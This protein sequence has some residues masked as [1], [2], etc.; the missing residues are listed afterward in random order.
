MLS[1]VL[2]KVGD[3]AGT[4]G[5][6]RDHATL[7]FGPYALFVSERRLEK[8]GRPV[9]L[10]GRAM[11]ILAAL[12]ARAG[13][14]VS[15]AELSEAAWPGMVVEEGSLRFH[16]ATLRRALGEEGHSGP[17]LTTVA[18]R[19]YCFTGAISRRGSERVPAPPEE[20][21]KP[22]LRLRRMVG[23][24][25]V[26]AEAAAELDRH[27]FLTIVGPPGIG[28]T[29]L[30][31]WLGHELEPEFEDSVAF[32]DLG[33]VSG[34]HLVQNA[35][36]AAIG[37]SLPADQPFE[38]LVSLLRDK[39]L[40]LIFDGCEHV[41]D[42]LA[43]LAELLFRHLPELSILTTSRES[44]R[45]EGERVFRMFPLACPP[46]CELN[47]ETAM[48][49]PAV[50][51][52]VDRL[53]ADGSAYS[54]T[55]E[56]APMVAEICR[57]LDGI[58]LA[59]ELAASR[60]SA[61]GIRKTASLLDGYLSLLWRGRRTAP[62]RHQTLSAALDWSHDLLTAQER[63]VFRRV[64]IFVGLF[65]IDAAVAVAGSP[66]MDEAAVLHVLG[67]LVA[68]SLVC[69]EE[70]REGVRYRLLDTTRVYA[71]TKLLCTDEAPDVARRH[72]VYFCDLLQ[73]QEAADAFSGAPARAPFDDQMGNVRGALQWTAS[74]VAEDHL[75]VSLAAASVPLFLDLSLPSECRDWTVRALRSL[76]E[77]CADPFL[78]VRLQASHGLAL[79]A[80]GGS[81]EDVERAF[82]RGLA[83]ARELGDHYHELRFLGGLHVL[84]LRSAAF[85][86]ALEVAEL[87][88]VAASSLGD[89]TAV[90]MAQAMLAVA[91]QFAGN[92][93]L[94]RDY[95]AA[96]ARQPAASS[97][98]NTMQLGF[99][100]RS[101]IRCA[102]AR[103]LW[104]R[105]HPLSAARAA[106][107][108]VHE[109]SKLD[110]PAAH[111]VSLIFNASIFLWIEDFA[112]AEE[113]VN[114]LASHA[115]RHMVAPH[116]AV[117]SGLQGILDLR[118]GRPDLGAP[119]ISDALDTLKRLRYEILSAWFLGALA[120]CDARLGRKDQALARADEAL[121]LVVR[122]G[123][124]F[125]MPDLLRI[126][127]EILSDGPEA[128]LQ[129][130][131]ACFLEA[132][133]WAQTQSAPVWELRAAISLAGVW[134]R[135]DRL[136]DAIT[137]LE[138]A[139]QDMPAGSCGPD[140]RNGTVMLEALRAAARTRKPNPLTITL[141]S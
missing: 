115:E 46:S 104:L 54:L 60:V 103:D 32:V 117:C 37:R 52:F 119:R 41:I 65:S 50:Q 3:H 66:D 135:G 23:S 123:D 70:A 101:R 39:R 132:L 42:M 90:S 116:V 36:A 73:R 86:E 130:A 82:R 120:E 77:G 24:D 118:K 56:D 14:V 95:S 94:A 98:S 75:F 48:W 80:T 64:A 16:I 28:K 78:E 85:N 100:H 92:H 84:L 108:A 9:H 83:V 102:L 113:M 125:Q 79:M 124:R 38:T 19:G 106:W 134:Q 91:H 45:A 25:E 61:Y 43:E 26:Y 31:I 55:D 47:A 4:G 133:A 72:A 97:R 49:Y 71:L 67:D 29:S 126:K 96:A 89:D 35:I 99:D 74:A 5:R 18:G 20:S 7:S 1:A 111:G 105:G 140:Q 22:P 127:G 141:N 51:L 8:E 109:V 93:V 6:S 131:A 62:P 68:K 88:L 10:G 30:A 110:N 107:D 69:M 27:R 57:K 112:S 81:R 76:Q 122:N 128:D 59:L 17:Y 139:L 136:G 15:K 53:N 12:V 33:A 2:P 87:A 58:P 44:L 137:I 138:R 21:M 40:L 114:R 13:E 11:D 129:G 63:V 121:A 34:P